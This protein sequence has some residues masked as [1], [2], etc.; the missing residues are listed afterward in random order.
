MEIV[1]A[2]QRIFLFDNQLT[3]QVAEL[4]AWEKKT[5]AFGT[6]NK[7]GS[8]L[9]HPK[10]DD[11]ELI[12]H[13]HRYQPFW[14]VIAQARYIYDRNTE[15][16]VKT[17]GSEVKAVTYLEK[18]HEISKDHICLS[19][20]EH[21]AQEEK[22]EVFVDAITDKNM[23]ELASYLSFSPKQVTGELKKMVSED[24]ILVPPQ[25]RISAIMRNTLS[26]MIK[27]IQADKIHEETIEVP[28]VDLYYHPIYAFQYM[29]KSKGKDAIVEIDAVTGAVRS[30][31]RVFREYF[32]K[33]LDQ[34]FLFD[35][36][37]DAMGLLIPGGSIVVKA[38]KKYI[39]IRK[40]KKNK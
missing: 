3:S 20:T 18:K 36:G 11:F 14:H 17:G 2:D 1:V 12:Y 5:T 4:K 34:D 38:A 23:P 9:S 28:I 27:G 37:A 40:D 21:C 13:E 33:V 19:V 15:Y 39:D 35:L 10:D 16:L 30:G 31:S 8:F 22:E 32:G 7:V 25:M 29:W 26:K 6:I 24:S